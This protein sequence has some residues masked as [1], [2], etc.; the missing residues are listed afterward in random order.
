MFR[1][2]R[3]LYGIDLLIISANFAVCFLF[4]DNL[5]RIYPFDLIPG[6]EVV[7]PPS[8]TTLYLPAYA[9]AL[10]IWAVL[11]WFRSGYANSRIQTAG[12]LLRQLSVNGA[13]FLAAYSSAAFLLKFHFLS[14]FFI[15]VYSVSTTFFLFAGRV[16]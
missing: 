7:S 5:L 16:V 2:R 12:Q 1:W 3:I 10:A 13:L 14:R 11:L 8:G 15:L 4:I 9:V 6:R